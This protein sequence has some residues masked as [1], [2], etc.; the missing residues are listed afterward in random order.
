MK[1]AIYIKIL[2]LVFHKQFYKEMH[3]FLIVLALL[4]PIFLSTFMSMMNYTKDS[5]GKARLLLAKSIPFRGLIG[6]YKVYFVQSEI[7]IVVDL[8][9]NTSLFP[10]S[11]KIS[12]SFTGFVEMNSGIRYGY[13]HLKY[14][15]FESACHSF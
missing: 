15:Q 12:K 2:I 3:P 9:L 1:I 6:D 13:L 4:N 8:L 5:V 14:L 11:L 7:L 10:F